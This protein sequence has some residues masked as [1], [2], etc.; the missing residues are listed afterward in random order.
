MFLGATSSASSLGSFCRRKRLRKAI[1]TARLALAWPTTY[2]SSSATISRGVSESIDV[3]VRSGS[4]ID[5]FLTVNWQLAT[6]NWQLATV[7]AL[8]L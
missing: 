1:A 6:G 5:M 7:R 4:E 2:L 3:V 8:P